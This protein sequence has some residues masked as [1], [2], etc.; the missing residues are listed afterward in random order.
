MDASPLVKE[1]YATATL[2]AI[3]ADWPIYAFALAYVAWGFLYLSGL[4][5]SAFGTLKAYFWQWSINFGLL[6][7]YAALVISIVGVTLRLKRRRRLG[8]LRVASPR[9]IG[10]LAAGVVLLLT[11]M[12]LFTSMFSSV[13]ASFPLAHGFLF[14]A[15]QADIDEALHFGVAPWR[16]LYSV[17]EHRLVLQAIEF[18][19]NVLWFVVCYFTLFWVATSPRADRIRNR[20]LL[21]WMS[22]WTLI[23]TIMAG[24]WL[25]AGPAFYGQ[26]TGDTARFA[27]QVDFL[28]STAGTLYSVRGFQDYLWS[29]YS[30][31]QPGIGSG[32]SAFPSVHVALITLNALFA[33]EASRRVG[34]IMWVYVAF[35]AMSSVYL[36]W[37]YAIDGYVS[38]VVTTALYWLYRAAP[39]LIRWARSAM[40]PAEQAHSASSL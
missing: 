4:G 12:L 11:A 15:V 10:R 13:K 33:G 37:H 36:G 23:G 24:A 5:L 30:S 34:L 40:A 9:R 16:L 7:P 25:S 28:S 29:L 39:L 19:Y 8:Y 21:T 14:D 27:G 31:G 22:I 18:N 26:V 3:R 1:G 20:Y 17:A 38:I 35:V 32:I 2:R 6:G